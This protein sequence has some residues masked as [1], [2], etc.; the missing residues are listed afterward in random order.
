MQR[1]ILFLIMVCLLCPGRT[2]AQ[3]TSSESAACDPWISKIVSIQGSVEVKRNNGTRWHPTHLEDI[4]CPGDRIRVGANSR[5]AIV[6]V[7]ETVMRLDQRTTIVIQGVETKK[8]FLLDL[9]EGA[10]HFFSRKARNLKVSTPFVNGVVKGTEFLVRVDADK[11]SIHLFE[12]QVLAENARGRLLLT[13]GQ[14]AL[15]QA[16]EGPRLETIVRPRDASHWTLYYPPILYMDATPFD[17]TAQEAWQRMISQ[18][19]GYYRNNDLASA[20]QA[21]DRV[22][23][24]V[25]D[26]RFYLYRAGLRLA[27]GQSTTAQSDI[28]Q[29][30]ALDAENSAAWA[31]RAV[32][33]VVQNKKSF[34]SSAARKAVAFDP[35]S[36]AARIA[37]SYVLQARFD[38]E[39]AHEQVRLAVEKAPK[40]GIAWARLAELCLSLEMQEAALEAA[41]K[42]SEL[43]PKMARAQ[44]VFGYAYLAQLKISEAQKR[45]KQAIN[46]DSAAPLPRLGLGLA[47]IHQGRLDEGRGHIEIAAGLDPGNALIRSYLAKAYFDEKRDTVAAR[48]LGIAK[49][50]DPTDPTPWYYD[51]LRKQ[52]LNRPVEALL[53]IQRS[54]HLNAN[55]APYRS[56]LAL[57]S[58]LA[59]RSASVG[60]IY[61]DLGFEE[62]A[63]TQG[64]RSIEID[65]G[66]YSA[67]RLLADSYS[68]LPRHEV[69][70]VSELLQS[71]LLQPLNVTPVQPQL[72]EP[73][74]FILD[75]EGPTDQAFNEFNPLFLRNRIALQASGVAGSNDTAGH[76]IVQSGLHNNLS[77]SLG[78]F[79]YKTDGFRKNNDR[80]VELANVFTQARLSHR[81]SLLAEYRYADTEKGDLPLRFEP[82]NFSPFFREDSLRQS[83]RI[84]GRYTINRQNDLIGTVIFGKLKAETS[85]SYPAY[86]IDYE[87]KLD[88]KGNLVEA[89]HM[90][91][92]RRIG[93][94]SGIGHFRGDESTIQ[95]L[96]P[97]PVD[98]FDNK[99]DHT[100][101]YVYSR[102]QLPESVTWTLG[103][104]ADFYER[105]E[106]KHDQFNPKF[107]ITW[108]PT[109]A[110]TLRAAAFRTFKR[111]LIADQTI[112]PTQVA[113]FN[114]LFD[115]KNG[116]AAWRYG[117]AT[118]HTF[119]PGLFGG[120][121]FTYFDL[122]VPYEDLNANVRRVDWEERTGRAYLFWTPF[123]WMSAG[124]NYR[125]ERF[126]R[127]NEFVGNDLFTHLETHRI[128]VR[129]NFFCPKG[130]ILKLQG[131]HIEQDG[132]FGDPRFGTTEELSDQFFVI[133]AA[134]G[135]RLP[136][137]YGIVTLAVKNLLDEQFNYQDTDSAN[138]VISPELSFVA[139]VTL[140][141]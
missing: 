29:A 131:T 62:L 99:V 59:A 114:Q 135:Y 137:R 71:Q 125:Y 104:S 89:Q 23:K 94:I 65:P 1:M 27:V 112:E 53:D 28:E 77:Y 106:D 66:N 118:D 111:S 97:G 12:G 130:V 90:Y 93:L 139:K 6:L 101:P 141:L 13:E 35:D 113:G 45:F 11:A 60:R 37:L 49:E 31:L 4:F 78:H 30:L 48:Q 42:A 17:G 33:A 22:D 87:E 19:I 46:L 81:A 21:I 115:D 8:T 126:E 76:D 51:A 43:N 85:E 58:D 121:A 117:V 40:N 122:E 128:P 116:T 129:L 136:R 91:R 80:E 36:V 14:S 73:G 25:D 102:I 68:D 79:H 57:D 75:S 107:G 92:S 50:L 18:S 110:T 20:H 133:D 63:L 98:R 54:I 61:R 83:C 39:K 41:R 140:N 124:I 44:T 2:P 64:S 127:D 70:R 120:I 103:A 3:N 96:R 119:A 100:T 74:L 38:L 55:R 9:L 67:H 82:E 32:I 26:L 47:N 86:G 10:A 138:P 134:V 56:K 105:L 5:A 16:N 24:A 132:E 69:A 95:A 72:A 123:N 109:S 34:A 15:V 52:T 108:R 84:G 88:D 7:N